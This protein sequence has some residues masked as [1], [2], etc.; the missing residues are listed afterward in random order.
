MKTLFWTCKIV[1]QKIDDRFKFDQKD[2]E[3]IYPK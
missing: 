2:S 1:L 3:K